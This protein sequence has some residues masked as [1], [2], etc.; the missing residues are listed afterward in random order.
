MLTLC[1]ACV[2]LVNPVSRVNP[3]PARGS[4][5]TCC[6]RRPL[7][8]AHLPPAA[9]A[10]AGLGRG[11]SSQWCRH[12]G[13]PGTLGTHRYTYFTSLRKCL[14]SSFP[15]LLNKCQKFLCPLYDC[16]CS[17]TREYDKNKSSLTFGTPCIKLRAADCLTAP[18]HIVTV[19]I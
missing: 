2:Y 19:I 13:R 15:G 17:K 9:E 5:A 3:T 14:S 12:F 10:A 16:T 8:I 6:R 1:L 7:F 4:V 18:E 11:G